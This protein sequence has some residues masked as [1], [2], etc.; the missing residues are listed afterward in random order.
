MFRV[1]KKAPPRS[2]RVQRID[3]ASV[4][5]TLAY[6]ESDLDTAPELQRVAEAVRA[7]LAEIDRIELTNGA[8]VSAEIT[9]VRFVPI[10]A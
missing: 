3:L 5:D 1:F 6:I 10:G 2:A 7:A 8:A 9:D 4:R